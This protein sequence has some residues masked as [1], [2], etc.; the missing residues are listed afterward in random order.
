MRT[1]VNKV[2][3]PTD[4]IVPIVVHSVTIRVHLQHAL[5]LKKL[6]LYAAS[7]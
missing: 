1:I 6:N 4:S 3:L 7:H 2:E 5:L